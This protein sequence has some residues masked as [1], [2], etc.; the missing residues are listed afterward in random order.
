MPTP[1]EH[2]LHVALARLEGKVDSLIGLHQR[3]GDDLEDHERRLREVETTLHSLATKSDIEEIESRRE[4]QTTERQRKLLAIA[5]VV[6]ALIVPIEAA[7]VTMVI[8]GM[9]Q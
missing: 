8:Q 2:S 6:I 9:Q 1:E 7:V 3:Q 5:G 4:A